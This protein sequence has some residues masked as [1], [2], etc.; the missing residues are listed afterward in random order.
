MIR[1]RY[2][3]GRERPVSVDGTYEGYSHTRLVSLIVIQVATLAVK[4]L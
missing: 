4:Q 3:S 1:N 2:E